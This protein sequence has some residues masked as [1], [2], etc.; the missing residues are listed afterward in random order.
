MKVQDIQNEQD[1]S[2]LDRLQQDIINFGELKAQADGLKKNI[3][4]LNTN[5]KAQMKEL[6]ETKVVAGNFT[7]TYSVQERTSLNEPKLIQRLKELN[8]TAAIE[9]KEVVNEEKVKDLIYNDLLTEEQIRDCIN[10]TEVEVLKVTAKK[11]K[12]VK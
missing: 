11:T 8:L 1:L 6:G 7:A 3:D 10:V 2:N 12:G 5:I 4:P 9:I